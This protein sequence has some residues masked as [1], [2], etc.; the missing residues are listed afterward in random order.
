MGPSAVSAGPEGCEE[1]DVFGPPRA[2]IVEAALRNP[3]MAQKLRAA[4]WLMDGLT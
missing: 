4:G 2:G 1:L 3:E